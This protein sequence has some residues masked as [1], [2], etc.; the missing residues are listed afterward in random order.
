M[1]ILSQ[2]RMGEYTEQML[3]EDVESLVNSEPKIITQTHSVSAKTE[4][5]I[6][7]QTPVISMYRVYENYIC[8]IL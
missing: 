5:C 4:V 6:V 7:N 2:F 8:P 3:R 1:Y